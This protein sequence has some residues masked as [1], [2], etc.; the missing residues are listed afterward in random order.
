MD[1]IPVCLI[2]RK[3]QLT[4]FNLQQSVKAKCYVAAALEG[5]Q[6]YIFYYIA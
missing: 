3:P 1:P 5:K 4:R 2:S 6:Q